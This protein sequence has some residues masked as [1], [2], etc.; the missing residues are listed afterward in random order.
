MVSG[1]GSLCCTIQFCFF[2]F[3]WWNE[4]IPTALSECIISQNRVSFPL[5]TSIIST[6]CIPVLPITRSLKVTSRIR[7]WHHL[8][9]DL[10]MG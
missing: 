10:K 8:L 1:L 6:I 5:G 9:K 4:S 2:F 3:K 7:L